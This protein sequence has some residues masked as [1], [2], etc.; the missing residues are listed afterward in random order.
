MSSPLLNILEL[1]APSYVNRM[2]EKR[3]NTLDKLEFKRQEES[4]RIDTEAELDRQRKLSALE[5]KLRQ[6][7]YETGRRDKEEGRDSADAL[8]YDEQR[9][10][11]GRSKL[12]ND[13]L[14]LTNRR[15]GAQLS[16][17]EPFM[18]INS[19]LDTVGRIFGINQTS[20]QTRQIQQQTTSMAEATKLASQRFG[21]ESRLLEAQLGTEQAR[22]QYQQTLLDFE[23]EKFEVT[24]P[25]IGMTAAAD[26]A[27]KM[28]AVQ[29]ALANGKIKRAQADTYLAQLE[30][31][32]EGA[33]MRRQTERAQ[34]EGLLLGNKAQQQLLDQSEVLFPLQL[35]SAKIDSAQ[36]MSRYYQELTQNGLLNK[37]TKEQIERARLENKTLSA[38]LEGAGRD[39]Q[40]SVSGD[41][42]VL[43]NEKTGKLTKISTVQD[44][45]PNTSMPITREVITD[46]IT[47]APSGQT[48][49]KVREG[50]TASS[51]AQ[52]GAQTSGSVSDIS[53]QRLIPGQPSFARRAGAGVS[54]VV[55]AI[56]K[57]GLTPQLNKQVGFSQI[58][59]SANDFLGGLLGSDRGGGD[60][61]GG[62]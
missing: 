47:G 35:G 1:V 41:S 49:I 50:N 11:L 30:E 51:V 39:T 27:L 16:A 45:D 52:P 14:A 25:F 8:F 62:Q 42:I 32:K 33:Q 17:D 13:M 37:L 61:L 4:A 10:R 12:E 34:Y 29:E 23:K 6:D 7:R 57:R 2:I 26:Y 5:S 19:A 15:S 28:A 31:F 46:Y 22:Q 20:A 58:L 55:D 56:L 36:K 59:T 48:L 44:I 38:E 21:V 24:K 9:M 54:D 18:G 53:R 60:R 40:V 3:A 43:F